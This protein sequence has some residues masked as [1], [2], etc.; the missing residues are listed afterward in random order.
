MFGQ[1]EVFVW[2]VLG[3]IFLEL[4]VLLFFIVIVYVIDILCMS[5]MLIFMSNMFYVCS[6]F[7]KMKLFMI[8]VFNKVDVKD[9]FFVKEWMMDYEVFQVVFV[10]DE[11]SNVFGGVEGGDGVGSGYMGGFI[12]SMSLMFEEFYFYFSVVGVSLFFGIGIDEFFEVVVEKIEEFKKDYQLELDWRCEEWEKNKEK[13]CEKQFVKMM[14]DMNMGDLFMFKVV[15]DFKVGDED[16]KDVLILS[17]DEDEDEDDID[18]DED[19]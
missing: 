13:Q 3:I 16:E 5:L 12:N 1:I 14:I 15:V 17:F 19:D 7:Y 2:L 4:F 18:I 9:L 11:N 8:L 10:E 6:I